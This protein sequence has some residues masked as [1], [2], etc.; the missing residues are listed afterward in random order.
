[1]QV[2]PVYHYRTCFSASI[3][4][5]A[6]PIMSDTEKVQP[7]ISPIPGQQPA[8]AAEAQPPPAAPAAP[9]PTPPPTNKP[10]RPGG[11]KPGGPREA[12]S[13]RRRI[14]E[15]MP[16]LDDPRFQ[17]GPRLKDLD[18]E[19]ENELEAALAGMPA[20]DFLGADSSSTVQQRAGA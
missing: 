2:S 19:I 20:Q 15:P 10:D 18:A 13:A 7:P 16:S 1:S 17:G 3:V 12:G 9:A 4:S 8:T 11:K 5:S 14:L 6:N